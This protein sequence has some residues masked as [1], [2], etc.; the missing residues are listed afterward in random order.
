M[1]YEEWSERINAKFYGYDGGFSE[2]RNEVEFKSG[3]KVFYLKNSSPGTRAAV[4]I[5]FEDRKIIDGKTEFGWFL[6]FWRN[7]LKSGTIPVKLPDFSGGGDKLYWITEEPTWTGQKY[8]EVSLEF[9]E[10]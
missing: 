5:R 9:E 2:N 7:T 4:N 10:V 1:V 3:R 6:D 8:K